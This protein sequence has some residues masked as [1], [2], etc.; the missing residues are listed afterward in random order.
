M[1]ASQA[2]YEKEE[3]ALVKKL[4]SKMG[5]SPILASLL[6]IAIAV[7]AA[8][9]TYAWVTTFVTTQTGQ[10]GAV[11][12]LENISFPTNTTI[13]I[14]VRNWGTA[15]AEIVAVY[16]G[17]TSTNLASATFTTDSLTNVVIAD[18]SL[19]ITVTYPWAN[20]TRYYFKVVTDTNEQ[21]PFAQKS[22]S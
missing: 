6:L 7:A 17:T 15:D 20:A 14:T 5:V 16:V 21:L 1:K 11:L 2:L 4:T 13:E 9:I 12:G 8:V 3:I 22:P 18:S 10:A 19:D